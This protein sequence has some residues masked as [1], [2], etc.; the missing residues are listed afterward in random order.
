MNVPKKPSMD[1]QMKPATDV[2][3]KPSRSVHMKESMDV[4][5]KPS[6]NVRTRARRK[7]GRGAVTNIAYQ[8]IYDT[9]YDDVLLYCRPQV[10]LQIIAANALRMTVS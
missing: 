5:R 1:V 9:V 10:W 3:M 7:E 2:Q 4:A 8:T 6:K